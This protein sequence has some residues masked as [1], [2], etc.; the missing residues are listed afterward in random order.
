[1]S[2][3]QIDTPYSSFNAASHEISSNGR[4]WYPYDSVTTIIPHQSMGEA[5]DLIQLTGHMVA[6]IV[7][8]S[9]VAQ[10]GDKIHKYVS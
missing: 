1:M 2:N 8:P 4:A 9:N 7:I 10:I 6:S 5:T 3:N